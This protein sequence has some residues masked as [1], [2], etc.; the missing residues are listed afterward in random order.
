MW[1]KRLRLRHFR[2]YGEAEVAFEPGLTVV[3]GPNGAGKTSLLEAVYLASQL[4]SFRAGDDRALLGVGEE[5]GSVGCRFQR[6]GREI[7]VDVLLGDVPVRYRLNGAARRRPRDVLGLLR[8]VVF[9]PDDLTLVK[10]PPGERRAFLDEAMVTVAPRTD[11]TRADWERVLRQRNA[12]LKA[13]RGKAAPPS[14][15]TWTATLADKGGMLA[16]ERLRLV[17][18]LAPHVRSAVRDLGGGEAGIAYDSDWA[19]PDAAPDAAALTETLRRVLTDLEGSELDR[20]LT[21]AGP[22]RDDLRLTLGGR[23]AR[24]QASQ[25]EQRTIAL[26][27][28]MAVLRRLDDVLDEAPVLLLDDVLSELDSDRSAGLL[29]HLPEAQT[30]LT[31]AADGLPDGVRA[32]SLV[33]V[34][35]G[36]IMT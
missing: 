2:T 19:P 27:L 17:D 8:A 13:V 15:E 26:A 6:A 3:S 33:R 18:A 28:R 5:L 32:A 7:E 12:L 16:A 20:G 31:T 34:E 25:G 29:A 24:T 10:G 35:S 22:H 1:V 11:S 36:R 14:L 4:R 23:D 30:L 21:L 9:S